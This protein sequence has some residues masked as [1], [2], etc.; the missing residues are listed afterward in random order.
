MS[1]RL[2]CENAEL[3][4]PVAAKSFLTVVGGVGAAIAFGQLFGAS[5]VFPALL[6]GMLAYVV[7]MRAAM[8]SYAEPTVHLDDRAIRVEGRREEITVPL[9]DV[10]EGYEVPPR[11]RGAFGAVLRLKQGRELVIHTRSHDDAAR[12]LAHASVAPDQRVLRMP[13]RRSLGAVTMALAAF[14][15]TLLG[16]SFLLAMFAPRSGPPGAWY[17]LALIGVSALTTAVFLTKYGYPR[18]VIGADGVRTEGVIAPG[19]VRYEDIASVTVVRNRYKTPVRVRLHLREGRPIDLPLVALGDDHAR[20]IVKRIEDARARKTGAAS[21]DAL[22]RGERDVASWRE[23]LAR[24]ATAEA[25][26]RERALGREDFERVLADASAPADQ[27]V[28]AAIA[29]RVADPE[30]AAARVRVAADATAD[31]ELRAALLDQADDEALD[32]VTRPRRLGD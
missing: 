6:F 17:P 32:R 8:T 22:A 29:L 14:F 26:F 23:E 16:A 9:E 1:D 21:L 12:L 3:K 28:G 10:V 20:A 19:F 18:V 13:L 4:R 15:G 5:A 31:E 24:I 27:R 30:G 25:G 7:V 2:Q 11:T